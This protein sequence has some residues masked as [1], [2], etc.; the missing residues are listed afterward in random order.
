M[1]GGA[2]PVIAPSLPRFAVCAG[3]GRL[4][5]K[6][7][8]RRFWPA[9]IFLAFWLSGWA[10]GE[11]G[12]LVWTV[13]LVFGP[14]VENAFAPLWLAAWTAGGAV[15]WQVLLWQPTG[16]EI[17]IVDDVR[18]VDVY[19]MRLLRH[20]RDFETAR[21][22]GLRVVI[23][24]IGTEPLR[25]TWLGS[26]MRGRDWPAATLPLSTMVAHSAWE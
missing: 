8:A 3:D 1:R 26:P 20:R 10:I 21:I 25:P 7:P 13:G 22:S 24:S 15:L 4:R 19:E 14:N 9:T 16:R 18:L 6:I 17:V 12:G 5:I 2:P 23:A 11:L